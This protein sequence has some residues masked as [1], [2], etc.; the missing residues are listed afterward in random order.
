MAGEKV[1]ANADLAGQAG[2]THAPSSQELAS[3]VDEVGRRL[4][5]LQ[6]AHDAQ[7]LQLA[8]LSDRVGRLEGRVRRQAD[9][10]VVDS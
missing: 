6:Q 1:E 7:A 2:I 5:T 3:R 4:D 9:A 8:E 10:E